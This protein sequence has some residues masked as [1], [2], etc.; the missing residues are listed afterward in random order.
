MIRFRLRT[1]SLLGSAAVGLVVAALLLDGFHL[2]T[3]GFMVA[4]V[5]FA[6]AQNLLAQVVV[7]LVGGLSIDGVSA[8]VLASLAVWPAA[9]F[10]PVLVLKNRVEKRRTERVVA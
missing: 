2:H 4:L 6:A 3:S 7:S 5:A 9:M 10:P 1:V 8:W